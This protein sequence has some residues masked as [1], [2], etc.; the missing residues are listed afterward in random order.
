MSTCHADVIVIG[1]GLH[2]CSSAFHLSRRGAKVVLLERDYCGRHASGANAGGVR[3]LGR[4][5]P[6]IP[7]ALASCDL[8]HD[9]HNLIG[10]DAGFVPDGQLKVAESDEDVE[11]LR[12]RTAL[13]NA[14]G[15]T[16]EELVDRDT[17]RS[18]VPAIA[19][20]V[21][22]G[23]WVKRDGYAIPYRAVTA[24]RRA[25]E[26]LGTRVHENTPVTSLKRIGDTWHV[27][28]PQGSFSADTVIN[29]SGAWAAQLSKMVGEHVPVVPTGLMLMITERV[30]PFISP[31]LGATKR[32]LSFKQFGNGTVLIGGALRCNHVDIEAQH[33]E[34]DIKRLSN[35]AQI[36]N[37]LFPFLEGVSINR[38]WSG[39]E[40]F[41]P[42]ELPVIGP[43]RTAPG[44]FH[45]FGFSGSGFQLGPIVGRLIAEMVMD[46][47][48]MLPIESFAVDR[49]R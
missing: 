41:T 15:W 19:P 3:T 29:A 9:L 34:L 7:L 35:S 32:S 2:G 33:A 10:D 20:H 44:L 21:T 30:R 6:E 14:Q 47:K 31:V 39:I 48:T 24:F 36:V 25:A 23:I 16:H 43:S 28:T 37:D 17:V 8:W 46:G 18:L 49:F 1:G 5:I 26:G 13:L 27:V 12:E 42:D 4:Q 45:A 11:L 40:A 38:A 22:G